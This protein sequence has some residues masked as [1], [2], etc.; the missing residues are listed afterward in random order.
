MVYQNPI[1]R[2]QNLR[3]LLEKAP[4]LN[5]TLVAKDETVSYK[6]EHQDW[7]ATSENFSY[8]IITNYTHTD[9]LDTI[10]SF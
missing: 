2:D 10:N 1:N 8:E 5:K 4:K 6:S 3:K 9:M 7:Y